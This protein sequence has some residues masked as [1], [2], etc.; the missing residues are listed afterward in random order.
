MAKAV[1]YPAYIEACKDEGGGA[2]VPF[3]DVLVSIDLQKR[4]VD[5]RSFRR[6]VERLWKA[7]RVMTTRRR[8]ARRLICCQRST[9]FACGG[10]TPCR[11]VLLLKEPL[12]YPSKRRALSRVGKLAAAGTELS[13][14]LFLVALLFD[15]ARL[16]RVLEIIAG[17]NKG[18]PRNEDGDLRP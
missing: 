6:E 13:R 4:L 7:G 9:L 14:S 10:A 5:K 1:S 3:K 17:R 18:A 2:F 12:V 15:D 11:F 16:G 8:R